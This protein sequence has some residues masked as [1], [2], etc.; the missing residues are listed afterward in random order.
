MVNLRPVTAAALVG[1]V[2]GLWHA[3]A[4]AGSGFDY[5]DQGLH[6]VA[7]V[8][9]MCLVTVPFSV[10]LA[11]LR[12]RSGSLF[13]PALAHATFNALAGPLIIAGVK[14]DSLL[15]APMGLLGALPMALLA[16]ALVAS[17]ALGE[18]PATAGIREIW[19]PEPRPTAEVS[20]TVGSAL[21]ALCPA[22]PGPKRD[23]RLRS[24]SA[25]SRA[26]GGELRTW[27]APGCMSSTSSAT[28]RLWPGQAGHLDGGRRRAD[29]TRVPGRDRG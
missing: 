4:I 18:A 28:P 6:R 1:L 15:V 22:T 23:E 19:A 27:C 13:A 10:V 14:S 5:G 7:G 9:A 11:W 25:R 3:P 26:L 29:Q 21:T 2:W 16:I 20:G 8:L 24:S 12:L 17:G